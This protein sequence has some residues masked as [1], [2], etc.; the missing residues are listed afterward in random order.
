MGKRQRKQALALLEVL[1]AI[2][3]V[4][5]GATFLGFQWKKMRDQKTFSAQVEKVSLHLKQCH[6]LAVYQQADWVASLEKKKGEWVFQA[7]NLEESSS[8]PLT[9]SL[10]KTEIFWEGE[11]RDLMVWYFSSTGDV[12]PLGSLLFQ[13][14]KETISLP[15]FSL[16]HLEKSY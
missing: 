8:P 3:L 5:L 6:R 7:K 1:L 15:L 2:A 10:S 11:P 14:G 9:F 12:D 16:F 13:N 4:A